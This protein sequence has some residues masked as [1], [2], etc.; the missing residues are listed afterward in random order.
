[1][2]NC[3][4]WLLEGNWVYHEDQLVA[5]CSWGGLPTTNQCLGMKPAT[6]ED[7]KPMEFCQQEDVLLRRW[8]V[9]QIQRFLP[10]A[11]PSNRQAHLAG[12]QRS[13]KLSGNLQWWLDAS[14]QMSIQVA[15][16]YPLVSS[17]MAGWEIPY[18]WVF[19]WKLPKMWVITPNHPKLAICVLKPMVLGLPHFKETPKW[20]NH[21]LMGILHFHPWLLEGNPLAVPSAHDK[22]AQ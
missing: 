22:Y 3:P 18:K 2:F 8:L 1:M 10:S 16:V 13:K 9:F 19:K 12:A 21:L 6:N 4:V 14:S 11:K 17:N 15:D 5:G 20:E 7:H